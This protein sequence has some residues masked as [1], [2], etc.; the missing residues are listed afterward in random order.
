MSHLRCA[1]A[2]STCGIDRNHDN[3]SCLRSGKPLFVPLSAPYSASRVRRRH[4]STE[5][6]HPQN[7]CETSQISF[8]TSFILSQAWLTQSRRPTQGTRFLLL[9]LVRNADAL[10]KP[11]RTYSRHRL[12]PSDSAVE[13]MIDLPRR[14]C[15]NDR[16]F[17]AQRQS[18]PTQLG[19]AEHTCVFVDYSLLAPYNGHRSDK[20]SL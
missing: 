7:A 8:L 17:S 10:N 19:V 5:N 18:L 13:T 14:S 9:T 11:I 16:D 12:L 4:H 20:G 6:F 1:S 2:L 15:E 3:I